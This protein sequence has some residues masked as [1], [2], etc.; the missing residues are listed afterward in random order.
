MISH[1]VVTST[2]SN[3]LSRLSVSR[4]SMGVG[5]GLQPFIHGITP[6]I[7]CDSSGILAHLNHQ[8]EGEEPEIAYVELH[9]HLILKAVDPGG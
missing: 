6:L 7:Q 1:Y 8:A 2:T 3:V 9:L 5:V 4:S